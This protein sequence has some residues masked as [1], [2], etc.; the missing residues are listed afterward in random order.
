MPKPITIRLTG[1][2]GSGKTI[3]LS[4]L[5]R[6]LEKHGCTVVPHKVLTDQDSHKLLVAPLSEK[7]IKSI[8]K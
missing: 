7:S 6:I 1:P 8:V 3:I 4:K 2:Q 5:R